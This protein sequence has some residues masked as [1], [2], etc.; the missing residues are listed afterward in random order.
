MPTVLLTLAFLCLCIFMLG[1]QSCM[2][3]HHHTNQLLHLIS[4][5]RNG[6]PSR[7]HL[8]LFTCHFQKL[9]NWWVLSAMH[10]NNAVS[11][12]Y[13]SHSWH[14]HVHVWIDKYLRLIR[15]RASWRW[16]KH[17]CSALLCKLW[18]HAIILWECCC[19]CIL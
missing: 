6:D 16:E 2:Q 5:T 8:H 14:W 12:M 19:Q 10:K 3:L 13:G 17:L 9:N 4:T 15:F 11:N 1:V 7:C 18:V